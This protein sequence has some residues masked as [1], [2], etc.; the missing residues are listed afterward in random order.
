MTRLGEDA[1]SLSG[2]ELG[3]RELADVARRRIARSGKP[4]LMT[5]VCIR[6]YN[7]VTRW[8]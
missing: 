5:E 7:T 2:Q 8:S 6:G 1:A 3:Q 4:P